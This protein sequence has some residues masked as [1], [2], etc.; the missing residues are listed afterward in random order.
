MTDIE[1]K[2]DRMVRPADEGGHMIDDDYEDR[3]VRVGRSV[4]HILVVGDSD[5]FKK[6]A[7]YFKTLTGLSATTKKRASR[8]EKVHDGS[9]G[10]GS[11]K[12][13]G[14]NFY[15]GYDI[16]GVVEPPLNLSY[17]AKL[18]EASYA[19][20]AA[21]NAKT[22]NIVGLGYDFIESSKSKEKM[23]SIETEAEKVKVG[24]R[25]RK[26][27]QSL[28][29]WLD[30]CHVEDEFAETLRNVYIDYEVTGNGYFEI[31]RANDGSVGYIGHI[32]AVSMRIRQK[33]D[34]FVQLSSDKAV[35]FKHFGKDTPDPLGTADG[36][37][38]EVI[39]IKK[40]SPTSSFYGI[41]DIVAATSAVAGIEFASRFNLDYFENKAVPRYVIV[42]KGGKMDS[43]SAS[44][45][46]DFFETGLRG[47]NH[48]TLFVPLPADEPDRK[49]SFEMKPVEAG[50]QDASFVNYNKINLQGI[51]MAHR[52]PMGKTGYIEGTALAA[53][54][55]ADKTF[56]ESV[57]RPEQAILEKKFGRIVKERTDAFYFKLTELTLT[58]EDTQSKIDERAIRNQ[59]A[60][61]NEIRARKGQSSIKGGDTIVDFKAQ[62]ASET[63]TTATG[64][65]ARDRARSANATDSAGQGRNTKGE[66]RTTP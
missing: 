52:V 11:K 48:R 38:N 28:F 25:L 23:D 63:K 10:A 41:P 4:E 14:V 20:Y 59:W 40:Y 49:S 16:L 24:R 34:G 65:R 5:P 7:S 12:Q 19:H 50:T 22:A 1:I 9:G 64:G 30:D 44:S 6:D 54:R 13:E 56:K 62:Q 39:H 60:V 2:P 55:D 31:G 51:F 17:L 18:Y 61:P 66:G 42:I 58:D 53:S 29:D 37:P 8:L 32:P 36:V 43:S 46:V 47:K 26:W 15:T 3:Q 57:C 33:R 27:R 35:F 21:V 45:I